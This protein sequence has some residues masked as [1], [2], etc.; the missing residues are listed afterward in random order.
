M[1]FLF[2]GATGNRA[3][4]SLITWAVARSLLE[5]DLKVGFIKPFGTYPVRM[6]GLWTDQDALLF[7]KVLNLEEPLDQICPYLFSEELW[8]QKGTGDMLKELKS[9]TQELSMGK[10]ILLI[11]GSSHIFFNDASCPVPDI[12]L[13]T[14]LGANFVLVDRY[15][16]TSTSIYSILSISSLLKDRIKGIILNKVPPERLEEIKGQIIP[17]LAKKGVSITT[18]L[19]DDPA[20][21]FRSLREIREV[22]DGTLLWG[23]EN[24]E[25]PVGGMT[26]GSADLKEELLLFKRVY[27]KIILLEPFSSDT[28]MEAPPSH[29]PIA[30]ILLTGGRTPA[31][32]VLQAAKRAKISLMLTKKDTFAALECLEESYPPLS[33]RD[34]GKARRMTDLMDRDGA[35]DRL[36]QSLGFI[37]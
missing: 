2:I 7:K 34:E 29:R 20:L 8:K 12:S 32:Q 1:S 19:P 4:K 26:V 23:E 28:G 18:A 24:L 31:P 35:L 9:L 3:G 15:M 36:I 33:F 22:L 25:Q 6:N 11:M 37:P 27:N 14:E 17:S 13:I 21:S 30:G 16:K 10:D 5:R